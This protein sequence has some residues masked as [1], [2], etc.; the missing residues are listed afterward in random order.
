[1]ETLDKKELKDLI[2]LGQ[3]IK[4]VKIKNLSLSKMK[5][6]HPLVL[7]ECDIEDLSINHLTME[8]PIIIRRCKI[9]QLI[10]QNLVCM[11]QLDLKKSTLKRMRVTHSEIHGTF[12]ISEANIGNTS[13]HGSTFHQ[14]C[15]AERSYFHGSLTLSDTTFHQDLVL[16][17]STIE[18]EFKAPKMKILGNWIASHLQMNDVMDCAYIHVE[19][20][21]F[22]SHSHCVSKATLAFSTLN[23]TIDLKN[24]MY[25]HT[26]NMSQLKLSDSSRFCFL[27][28]TFHKLV[29]DHELIHERLFNEHQEKYHLATKEY[30]LLRNQYIESHSFDG[31]DWAYYHLKRTARLA[32]AN[33]SVLNWLSTRLEYIFLD[34]GCG[35]GIHPFRT[36]GVCFFLILLFGMSY[37]FM[38]PHD[39]QAL[40]GSDIPLINQILYAFDLSLKVFSGGYS[41]FPAYGLAKFIA[42]FE[43]LLGLV[44]MG[45]F[46]VAIS[47][48][49][50]R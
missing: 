1:M 28:A 29:I 36:L 24:A 32:K 19:G 48:K 41:D 14:N 18:R 38:V 9:G 39:P 5:L 26:F 27:N 12:Q 10:A 23:G 44:F 8:H 6:E 15:K 2:K 50:I 35:Y 30:G 3:E 25:E 40:F 37:F 22:L 7:T 47:R 16:R 46:V 21:T 42:M 33:D 43:Y 31:E 4:N 45:L 13:L 17:H 34:I 20:N 49:I 11:Q